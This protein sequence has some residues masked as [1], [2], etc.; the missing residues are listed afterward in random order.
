DADKEGF[1]RSDRSLIQTIGRAAR[2]LNG[3]A[4]LYAAKITG[5]MERAI[6]ETN[7]RREK[8]KAYNKAHGI[9]PKGIQKAITDIMD[10]GYEKRYQQKFLQVAEQQAQ[11][12][13]MSVDQASREMDKLEKQMYEHAK[14]LEFEEA[15]AL[16]DK[17]ES[18]RKLALGAGV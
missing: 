15:A 5:S 10:V 4:I 18:L 17:I 9:T 7:R 12:A 8:Q 14:N 11:Y 13:H 6:D 1:L 16:R 2:N 3:K